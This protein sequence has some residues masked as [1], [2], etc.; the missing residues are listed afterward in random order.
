MYDECRSVQRWR[1]ST[2]WFSRVWRSAPVGGNEVS[3]SPGAVGPNRQVLHNDAYVEFRSRIQLINRSVLRLCPVAGQKQHRTA[4]WRRGERWSDPGP[5][6]RIGGGD[7][8]VAVE[9]QEL[10][11]RPEEPAIVADG[12]H[13]PFECRQTGFEGL[14][15]SNIEVVGRLVEQQQRCS[16]ELEQQDLE[17]SLLAAGKRFPH[18]IARTLELIATQQA[19]CLASRRDLAVDVVRGEHL[20]Q[21]SPDEFWMFVRL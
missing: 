1:V 13:G 14:G 11:E 6:R 9:D 5:F 15:G 19:H 17:T 8:A 21:R 20:D 2:P 7:L 3:P 18:L 4:G 10:F 16:A 12:D